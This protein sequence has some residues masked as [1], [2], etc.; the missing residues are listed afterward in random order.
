[1][2]P[3]GCFRQDLTRFLTDEELREPDNA[4][5]Y[6]AAKRTAALQFVRSNF[7]GRIIHA[8]TESWKRK[9]MEIWGI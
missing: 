5:Y 4:D 1:V 2:A 6:M 3:Y 9:L 7:V 8:S